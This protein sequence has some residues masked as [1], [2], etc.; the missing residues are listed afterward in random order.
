MNK[1]IFVRVPRTASTNF[2]GIIEH[3]Y[4]PKVI[5]DLVWQEMPKKDRVEKLG[6]G[7]YFYDFDNMKFPTKNI[8]RYDA[9]EGHFYAKKYLSLK[10]EYKFVTFLRD[11]V[12]RVISHFHIIISR[13]DKLG[14]DIRKFA[15]IYRN[16]HKALLGDDLSLYEFIGITEMFNF[17]VQQFYEKFEIPQNKRLK[18]KGRGRVRR[19]AT[20]RRK[21]T[22]SDKEYIKKINKED[23]EIYNEIKAKLEE[24]RKKIQPTRKI[25]KKIEKKAKVSKMPEQFRK[26]LENKNF[27]NKAVRNYYKKQMEEEQ[28][29]AA[30]KAERLEREAKMTPA[31]LK[32]KR[33]RQRLKRAAIQEKKRI[34]RLERQKQRRRKEKDE[35][36]KNTTDN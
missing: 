19:G 24:K 8:R 1:V 29:K 14:L 25:E 7:E 34:R 27:G 32:A 4:K 31:E 28:E 20:R 3:I 36:A 35:K 11:P 23:Y 26:D 2:T 30:R 22:D 21:I 12:A 5:R 17:S 10:D 15:Y 18:L 16:F 33:R 6:R 13:Q 9:I